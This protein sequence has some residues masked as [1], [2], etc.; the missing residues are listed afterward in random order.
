MPLTSRARKQ[1]VVI[2]CVTRTK[3]EWRGAGFV[4]SVVETR[5]GRE[6]STGSC[7]DP[8]VAIFGLH[9]P[10]TWPGRTSIIL[11]L[12]PTQALADRGPSL[13][14]STRISLPRK[15]HLSGICTGRLPR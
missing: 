11:P 4:T 13:V 2:Q 5:L 3:A 12:Y 14:C 6:A 10:K 1:R 9:A 7:A 8:D 15:R